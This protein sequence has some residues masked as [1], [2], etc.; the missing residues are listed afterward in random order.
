MEVFADRT[1]EL[2]PLSRRA[3]SVKLGEE[4]SGVAPRLETGR[5]VPEKGGRLEVVFVAAEAVPFA[6]TGGLADVIGALPPALER[7]GVGARVVIPC[8]R[9][10]WSAGVAIEATG[11]PAVM[12]QAL[13]S[14][15]PQGGIAVI[16]GNA[17]Q[18]EHW[19]L[20]PKQLNLGKRIL[21][22]WGGDNQPPDDF[23]RYQ[24][25]ITTGQLN[26]EPFLANRYPLG[27]I[28]RALDE[29][30]AGRVMR[31]I[32]EISESLD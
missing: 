14:V 22:T 30:E 24:R 7:I 4:G 2:G 3:G 26:C 8:H 11:R 5:D 19:P 1:E 12:Q 16:A 28:N 29:L 25:L 32:I 6:K 21:G 23:P 31:P 10:A 17:R 13:E 18:G 27:D 20:D 15:R 9:S